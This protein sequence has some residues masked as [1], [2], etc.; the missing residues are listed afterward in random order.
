VVILKKDLFAIG[1]ILVSLIVG[2]FAFPSLP[3]QL[4]IHWTNGEP[5]GVANKSWAILLMPLIM[6]VTH[7]L[8]QVSMKSKRVKENKNNTT[9]LNNISNAMLIFLFVLHLI[10]ISY[11]LGFVF[12]IKFAIGI[13]I[14]LITIFLA[15]P[16]QKTKPNYVYGLRTP[17]TLKD[18]RVWKKANLFGGRLFFVIG[19]LIVVLSFVIPEYITIIS[20]VLLLVGA[21]IS[22]Y[23]SYLIYKKLNT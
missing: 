3:S 14:G 22:V 19:F 10:I 17:W 1:I 12:S 5:K 13:L 20:I 16:V 21:L 4:P 6:L 8:L 7:L 23:A 9:I 11:G 18:E 2:I 15:N